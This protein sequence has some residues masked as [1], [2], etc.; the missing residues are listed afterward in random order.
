[1]DFAIGNIIDTNVLI[2]PAPSNAAA[3]FNSLGTPIKNCLIINT[4]KAPAR[5]GHIAPVKDGRVTANDVLIIPKMFIILKSATIVTWTGTIMA[6]IINP[7]IK[8][9]PLKLNFAYAYPAIA[10]WNTIPIVINVLIFKL[11]FINVK[12]GIE[13]ENN[14]L[15]YFISHLSIDG[16]SHFGGKA[17]ASLYGLNDAENTQR[18]G[19]IIIPAIIIM[20]TN[21]MI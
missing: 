2:G 14:F 6:T 19:A 4:P 15:K 10:P 1:M 5:P 17:I 7:N 8:F 20:T 21:K 11:F 16:G 3:S 12:N 9:L 18:N 13:S